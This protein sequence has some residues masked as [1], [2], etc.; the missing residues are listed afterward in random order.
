[1]VLQEVSKVMINK[2]L[3]EKSISGGKLNQPFK[4]IYWAVINK[5][6]KFK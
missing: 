2:N 3:K 1:M 6:N 5:I 4:N